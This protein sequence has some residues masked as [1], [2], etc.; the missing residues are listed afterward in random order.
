MIRYLSYLFLIIP[1]SLW[2]QENE[3]ADETEPTDESEQEASD[4]VSQEV[5]VQYPVSTLNHQK[6][7]QLFASGELEYF[8]NGLIRSCAQVAQINIG[9]PDKFY[10]PLY[11][12]GGA[13]S[14]SFSEGNS[15]HAISAAEILNNL[16][17]TINAGIMG[18]RLLKKYGTHTYISGLYQLAYK[19]FSGISSEDQTHLDMSSQI[20][21]LGA[22]LNSKAWVSQNDQENAGRAWIKL[23]VTTSFLEKQ[24][25]H[26]VYGCNAPAIMASTNIECGIDIQNYLNLKCGLHHFINDHQIEAFKNGVLVITAGFGLAK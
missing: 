20:V 3:P 19:T 25:M 17:G 13:T 8:N 26:L 18:K 21:S 12:I 9:D 22:L 15:I 2:S 14:P 10:L 24:K 5:L 7:F 4:S 23:M 16:G 11:I 6:F 1:L